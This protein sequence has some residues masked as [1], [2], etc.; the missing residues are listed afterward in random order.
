[1]QFDNKLFADFAK[2]AS[3]AVNT[4]GDMSREAS[5]Q[6]RVQLEKVLVKMNFVTR[7]EFDALREMTIKLRDENQELLKRLDALDKPANKTPS[8]PKAK[9]A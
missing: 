6:L 8:K 7:D 4:A 3:S 1:M 5:E 9:K 2:L